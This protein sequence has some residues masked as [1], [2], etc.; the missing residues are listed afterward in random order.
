MEID[1]LIDTDVLIEVFQAK[2]SAE[3]WFK[4]IQNKVIGIPI[5]VYLEIIQG[6]KNKRQQKLLSKQMNEYQIIHLE[7]ADSRL[8][9]KLFEQFYL[10]HSFGILDALIASIVRRVDK[11]LYTFNIRHFKIIKEIDVR[12]PYQR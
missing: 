8:A 11:P 2:Q 6:V 10:S 4:S 12:I 1:F 3:K 9:Q 7:P 5:V